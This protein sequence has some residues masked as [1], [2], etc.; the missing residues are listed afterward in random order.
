VL[1]T[2]LL[3]ES[4]EAVSQRLKLLRTA[5]ARQNQT[6]F[7]ARLGIGV[8]RWNM[9]ENSGQLSKQVAFLLVRN[10]PGLTLDWL[11]LGNAGGLPVILQRELDAAGASIAPPTDRT[12]RDVLLLNSK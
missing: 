10:F 9:M 12:Q 7:A 3:P 5:I 4:D 6:Q 8:A 1:H 2:T 11:F